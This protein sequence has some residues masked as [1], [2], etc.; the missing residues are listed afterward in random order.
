MARLKLV[1]C[2][3]VPATAAARRPPGSARILR[4]P[5]ITP[6]KFLGPGAAKDL[7]RAGRNRIS[8]KSTLVYSILLYSILFYLLRVWRETP[9]PLLAVH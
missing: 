8:E 7:H 6:M 9:I 1:Q 5:C 4:A 3:D 2:S